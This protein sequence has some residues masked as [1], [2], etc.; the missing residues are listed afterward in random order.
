MTKSNSTKKALVFALLSTLLCVSMLIGTTFAWFTDTASTAVNKIVSGNLDVKLEY[1]TAWDETGEPTA[2]ADAEGKTL[3]FRTADNNTNILWE[4]GC[5]YKLPEL[6]V[7]NN[8]TLA[9]K[10][11]VEI[12]GV[13]GNTG[14]MKVIN[15]TM[16]GMELGT[17][18]SLAKGATSDVLAISAHMDEAAGNEYRNQEITGIGVT[19][20]ATQDTVESDSNGNTYDA[21]ATVDFIPVSTTE[22]LKNVFKSAKA[23]E[24]VNVSLNGDVEISNNELVVVNEKQSGVGVGVGDINIQA[25]GHTIKTTN[26]GTRCVKIECSDTVR[27]ITITGAKIVSESTVGSSS[28][29]N[30]GVQIFSV[31]NA[32]INLVNCKIEMKS[33]DYSYPV[34]IGG[35]SENLTVNLTG[36]TLTGANCI[37]SFGK[38]CIVNITDCVLN[39]NYGPNATYCGNGIQDKNG[40]NNTYNIKNTVFNGANAQPWQTSTTTT[41][42]DL[43]GNVYNTTFTAE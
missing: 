37:E 25:N 13:D 39:S 24:S 43:G 16:N 14:L 30:R 8:G 38:N 27:N 22:E 40:T 23:G 26:N 12:S 10:F 28:S 29:E 4:P 7:V 32:T 15:F 11:K 18:I 42:H 20:Y 41:I 5:T 9:L 19:V 35:T 21:D 17:D 33:N 36:C 6:R 31:N 1:A 34:K 2:W 3:N